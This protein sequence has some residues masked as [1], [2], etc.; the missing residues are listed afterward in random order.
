[1]EHLASFARRLLFLSWYVMD[2]LVAHAMMFRVWNRAYFLF[3]SLGSEN[4]LFFMVPPIHFALAL[5]YSFI[6]I[7]AHIFKTATDLF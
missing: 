3:V 5:S 6:S 2:T 7:F 1:M 4:S